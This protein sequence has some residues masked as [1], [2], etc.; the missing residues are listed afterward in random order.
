[1]KPNRIIIAGGRDFNDYDR[2]C[3]FM[4]QWTLDN[5]MGPDNTD[6]I[7]GAAAGA[8]WF[9]ELWATS[10]GYKV[11]LFPANW[12]DHGKAAGYIR[13]KQM[14]DE[15]TGLVA[16][17]DGTSRGTSHMISV[18]SGRGLPIHIERY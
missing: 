7:S 13:N 10:R 14:A 3:A 11:M 17:W 15:A 5:D 18:M 2:L 1:M 9:G 4:D 16:W 6:F 12:T 8:D